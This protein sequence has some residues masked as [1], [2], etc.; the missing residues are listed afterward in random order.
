[1]L[2]A[3]GAVALVIPA[4]AQTNLANPQQ[5]WQ[6]KLPERIVS[7][8]P[9][10]NGGCIAVRTNSRIYVLDRDGHRSWETA[11]ILSSS[12]E[13]GVQA[14]STTCDWIAVFYHLDSPESFTL[15]IVRKDG[16]TTKVPLAAATG[17]NGPYISTLDIS[18]DGQL[19]AIGFETNYLWVVSREGAVRTRVGPLQGGGATVKFAEDSRHLLLTG[20]FSTGLMNLDGTWVWKSESRNLAGSRNLDLFAGLTAPMHGPQGGDVVILDA[21]GKVLWKDFAWDASMAVA[22]N[23]SLVVFTANTVSPNQPTQPPYPNAPLLND[24]PEIWVRDR[25]GNVIAHG[26]FEGRLAGVSSDSSCVLV[27]QGR[28]TLTQG[29]T[30]PLVWLAGFNRSLKEVWRVESLTPYPLVASNLLFDVNAD[31]IHA[32]LIPTCG[33]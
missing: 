33:K 11:E 25:A 26:P 7:V 14:I 29:K 6:A 15:Q 8:S 4:V 1:L 20:L 19:L 5:L 30:P 22:P 21:A 17:V 31:T 16:A 18:P 12:Y 2:L 3:I 9:A 32:Y 10:S 23:A 13:L 24:I 28:Y 27:V